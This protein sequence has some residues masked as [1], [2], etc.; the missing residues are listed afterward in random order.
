VHVI[1][2]RSRSETTEITRHRSFFVEAEGFTFLDDAEFRGKSI[3]HPVIQFVML[4]QDSQIVKGADICLLKSS[5]H[6]AKEIRR[7]KVANHLCFGNSP[8]NAKCN[9][10]ND[11]ID[12]HRS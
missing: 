12:G 3:A 6:V 2:P 1:A 5:S 4:R 11:E 8:T 7:T 10:N 9:G